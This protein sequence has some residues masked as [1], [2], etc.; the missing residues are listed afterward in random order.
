MTQAAQLTGA[1]QE[2]C[3]TLIAFDDKEGALATG[4]LTADHFDGPYR[5]VASRILAYR[6]RFGKAPGQAHIDDLFD[7]I[8]SDPKHKQHKLFVRILEGLLNQ[9]QGLN[10][11]YVASRV[12]AFVREQSLKVAVHD[13]AQR[14]QQGGDDLAV[15][16]ENILFKALK[17][18]TNP[19]EGGVFLG[20]PDQALGFLTSIPPAMPLGIPQFDRVGAGPAAGEL[21]LFLAPKGRGKT[22]FCTHVAK[23]ALLH[24]ERVLHISLEM[25]QDKM[26]RRYFQSLFAIAL[27]NEEYF[28]TFLDVDKLGRLD[29]ID[30]ESRRPRL[31][32]NDPKIEN[33]LRRELTPSRWGDKLSRLVIKDFPS[34]SLTIPK[35]NSYLDWLEQVHKFIPT[36]LIIDYPGLMAM[37]RSQLREQTGAMIIAL[38][39]LCGERNLACLAPHQTN[40]S[41]TDA[42]TVN[43]GHV[44]EDFSVLM[45][46]DKAIIHSQ[47]KAEKKLNLARLYLDKNR[48]DSD[49]MTVLIAQNY[50]TGQF[51]LGPSLYMGSNYQEL[52]KQT[53]PPQR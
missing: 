1:L 16:V 11:G 10:A 15:D 6:K 25:N 28:Q 17:T 43:E 4:L 49:G 24:G 50:T 2:S 44:S 3:L 14:Y 45:T 47:T 39:G 30:F 21:L 18:R 38:R 22:W 12:T 5:E 9:A 26:A 8:L 19:I 52:L 31:A 32:Y 37:D 41:S 51:M 46:T 40:R 53:L 34:G 42:G 48:G 13:A 27:R 29:K 33:I 36:L 20:D 7:D 23:Q 35:L